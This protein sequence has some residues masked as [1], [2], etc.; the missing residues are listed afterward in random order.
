M[1]NLTALLQTATAHLH[2]RIEALPVF[3]RLRVGA[4]PRP[5]IVSLLR[6]LAIIHAVLEQ[7][8]PR[9]LDRR[10]SALGGQVTAKLPLLMLDLDTLGAESLPSISEAIRYALECGSELVAHA[11]DPLSLI[12]PL[13]VLEES[14]RGGAVLKL[15]LAGCLDTDTDSLSYFGCYGDGTE[16]HWSAFC[17][18]LNAMEVGNEQAERIV[19][20]AVHFVEH[21]EKIYAALY[22]Y[23]SQSF[24]HHVTAVNPEAGDHAMPN[25]PQEIA[26]ALR[27]GQ[28]AWAK[29]PYLKHRFG[30][31]GKRFTSSDSCW[32]VTLSGASIETA[33]RSLVWLRTVLA[34]RGI[35]SAI[36]AAHLQAIS[37]EFAAEFVDQTERRARFE[38]FLS[39]LAC[40]R[41]TADTSESIGNLITQ[42]D[43]RL[44]R[45]AGFTIDS[46]AELITSAWLDE[47][48]GIRGALS[49]T[50]H[51]FVDS[52]RF[53]PD[54]IGLVHV[55]VAK[56]NQTRGPSC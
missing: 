38:P 27:A 47:R 56:L 42:F 2:E 21:I 19:S 24:K 46:T 10:V 16:A 20:S 7:E 53:S 50:L 49:A 32:L 34:S 28:A 5:A 48:S 51:W 33:T 44:H 15:A 30:D 23:G 13:Y 3:Q 54:W 9:S 1:T 39:V 25:H 36:L 45:C 52:A 4:L 6:S 43:Q 18:H 17:G 22:P 11:D 29:Y 35:P 40:E 8:I 41:K 31:R 14:Q 55:L 37:E 12:G 26:L